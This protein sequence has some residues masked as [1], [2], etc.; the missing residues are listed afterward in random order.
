MPEPIDNSIILFDG[1]CKFCHAS[2]QFVIKRDPNKR[3]RFCPLQSPKGQQLAQDHQ[4]ENPDLTS[5]ILL[6][7]DKVYKKSSAAL[8]I[9]RKLANPW[10]AL[11]VFII[12]P[13]FLRDAAYDFIGKHRY[14]WFGKFDQCI[15]P[16]DQTK[17]RFLD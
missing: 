15:I 14:Q 12:V 2:V 7:N 16:D 1:V 13:S 9:S 6:E 4:I 11:Y 17:E 10:P 3:F 8:R 5:M